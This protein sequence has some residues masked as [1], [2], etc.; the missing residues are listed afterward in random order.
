MRTGSVSELGHCLG[1]RLQLATGRHDGCGDVGGS[2]IV[3]GFVRQ[4]LLSRSPYLVP[5]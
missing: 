5:A 1:R 3:A 4:L 2:S